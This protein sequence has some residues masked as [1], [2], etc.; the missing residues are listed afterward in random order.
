MAKDL[1]ISFFKEDMKMVNKHMNACSKP[2]VIKEMQIQG[3]I[4]FHSIP[5]RMVIIK[6]TDNKKQRHWS[7]HTLQVEI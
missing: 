3:I 2:L 7:S 1:T 4:R 6:K 5:I